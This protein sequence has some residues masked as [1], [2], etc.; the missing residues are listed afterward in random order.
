MAALTAIA[1]TNYATPSAQAAF[2]RARL[3]QVRREADQAEANARQLREQAERAEQDAQ[4][5]QGKVRT[6]SAQ[7]AQA[8]QADSTYS[9]QLRRQASATASRQVQ[10]L[11][12]PTTAVTGNAW[13]FT[14]L[15]PRLSAKPWSDVNQRSTQG[16]VVNL[17]A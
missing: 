12:N 8:A 3:E 4:Q 5:S 10:S 2:G 16:R 7:L 17:T 9:T 13:A 14:D 15:S 1:A 6:A 11:L